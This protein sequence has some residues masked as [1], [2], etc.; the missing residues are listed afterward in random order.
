MIDKWLHYFDI[1]HRHFE[2]FRDKPVTIIEF[3]VFQGG[4]LQMWRKYFG[5]RARIVGVDIDPRCSELTGPG[6]EIHIGDQSDPEFLRDLARRVGP[7]EVVIDDGGHMM[8]QQLTTLRELW[9]SVTDGGVFLV[10]DLHTS[11]WT[12]YEG[13]YRRPGTF[14]EYAKT[15]VDSLHAWHSR[16]AHS[17]TVDDYT[18]TIGGMH[19]YDSVL[20]LDKATV[21]APSSRRIGTV[22]HDF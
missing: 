7:A 8:H 1:Y 5:R 13:G 22:H 10:E 3:G 16:D 2:K 14:I 4:S 17:F 18:R 6:I 11:Y 19:F 20:V 21:E 9:P 15:L 12:D